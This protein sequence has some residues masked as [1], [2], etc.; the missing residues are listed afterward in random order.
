VQYGKPERGGE[1]HLRLAHRIGGGRNQGMNG[2][3]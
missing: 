2:H 1:V 3:G